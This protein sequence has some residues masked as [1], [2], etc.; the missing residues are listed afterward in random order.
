MY[1]KIALLRAEGAFWKVVAAFAIPLFQALK[2]DQESK[3]GLNSFK[4]L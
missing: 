4:P 1:D 2:V 3:T